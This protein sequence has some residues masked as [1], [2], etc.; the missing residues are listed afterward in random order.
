[1]T[2]IKRISSLFQEVFEGSPYYGP[3]TLMTLQGITAEMA[4][5]RPAWSA[6]S[7]WDLVNHLTGELQY[8]LAVLKKT[9][10]PWIE[11]ET[12]WSTPAD[13]SEE[14][15]QQAL[16]D[17]TQANQQF[18]EAIQRLD[19]TILDQQPYRVRGPYYRM[20]HGTL[21]HTIFHTGQ[22]SLLTGQFRIE[23]RPPCQ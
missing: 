19:D 13:F 14:A 9:A 15:W 16:A 23:I 5:Q 17:L 10:G 22:I 18:I 3:S 12:T 4:R 6:H 2:E 8:A 21:Q 7:I 20:L 1:M 11:G